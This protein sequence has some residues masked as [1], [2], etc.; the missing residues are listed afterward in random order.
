MRTHKLKLLIPFF[1]LVLNGQKT[2]ELR[3]ND[4]DFVA[5]DTVYLQEYSSHDKAYTGRVISAEI[6]FVYRG[7]EYGLKEGYCVFSLLNVLREQDEIVER[8]NDATI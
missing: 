3:F 5:G 8:G 4:R 2:F 6:G 1:N 7:V